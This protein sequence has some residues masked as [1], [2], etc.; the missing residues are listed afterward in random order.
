MLAVVPDT[1]GANAATD[2]ALHMKYEHHSN[3]KPIPIYINAFLA[4]YEYPPSVEVSIDMPM[5]AHSSVQVQTY[6]IRQAP[7]PALTRKSFSSP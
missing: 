3:H 6:I 1:C 5:A 4:R 2:R 7:H